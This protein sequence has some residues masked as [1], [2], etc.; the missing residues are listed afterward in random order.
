MFHSPV[1]HLRILSAV[2]RFLNGASLSPFSVL[3]FLGNISLNWS[4]RGLKMNSRPS[5]FCFFSFDCLDIAMCYFRH[6]GL[7]IL[8]H[9]SWVSKGASLSSPLNLHTR[10]FT[11]GTLLYWTLGGLKILD[12]VIFSFACAFSRLHRY[13]TAAFSV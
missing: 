10:K 5:K 6:F 2:K 7:R 12:N 3:R 8:N 4:M 9:S 1:V 13:A 11:C